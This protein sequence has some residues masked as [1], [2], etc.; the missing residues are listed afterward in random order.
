MK[1]LIATRPWLLIL[2]TLVGSAMVLL[3]S[4]L[5]SNFLSRQN[6]T[7]QIR[8][9]DEMV[10][11]YI[12]SGSFL[13][14]SDKSQDRYAFSNEL[15]Q[16]SVHLEAYW[17]D[18]YEV[19]NKQYRLCVQEGICRPA[20]FDHDPN[21]N[22]DHQPVVSV[23][24]YDAKTYCHWVG[25]DL[26]TE[27]QW[28]KAAR[29]TAGQIY[30]WGDQAATCQYAVMG[31]IF[32]NGCGA[33]NGA[34]PV[35]SKPDG[36]SPYGLMDMSGNAAEWVEDWYEGYPGTSYESDWYGST[37]KV[38]RGGSWSVGIPHIRAAARSGRFPDATGYIGSTVGF[39]CAA[40]IQ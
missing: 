40:V 3:I 20:P 35:G 26:P 19:T 17:I 30:P 29:G 6:S 22:A 5:V 11:I 7:I 31:E 14:G 9:I 2:M 32:S 33:G 12:P 18:K 27:A 21:L 8:D 25:A 39:R 38:L 28:E 36:A 34:W 23:S 24:W 15:P 10:M 16:H 4:S 13:M 1:Q 37:V